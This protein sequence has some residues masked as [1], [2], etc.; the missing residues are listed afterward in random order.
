MEQ[1]HRQTISNIFFHKYLINN[2]DIIM[3]NIMNKVFD[4]CDNIYFVRK[5]F[6]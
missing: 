6:F 1:H 2:I 3:Y 4:A 5:F